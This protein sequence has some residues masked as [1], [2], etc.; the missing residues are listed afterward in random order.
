MWVESNL[1][2]FLC[3]GVKAYMVTGKICKSAIQMLVMHRV[4]A[5]IWR[6]CAGQTQLVQEQIWAKGGWAG[7]TGGGLGRLAWGGVVEMGCD[8]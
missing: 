1:A 2:A 5:P 8:R 3:Y 6:L 7:G 4:D